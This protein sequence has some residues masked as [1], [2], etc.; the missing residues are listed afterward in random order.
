MACHL[1]VALEYN[2][3]V[4]YNFINEFVKNN[5]EGNKYM[6]IAV[7][8][9]SPRKDK[10]TAGLLKRAA[11]G[12]ESLGIETEL[13]NLY[14]LD[15]KGCVSCFACKLKNG[16]SYGKCA[17]ADGLTPLLMAVQEA[18]GLILGSPIYLKSVTGQMRSF[19]ERLIFPYHTYTEEIKSLFG[20]ELPTAFI[21]TM[22]VTYEQM[23]EI[24]YMQVMKF[25]EE[26]FS[27]IFGSFEALFVNDTYQFDDYS[28][29]VV[30]TF[31]EGKKAR[32][33]EEQFPADCRKAFELGAR[34]ANQ[35]V[36][37]HT[38]EI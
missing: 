26:Y 27:R 11:E 28:K 38:T 18:D 36:K 24:G 25:N 13:V 6:K 4:M 7:V 34:I 37:L 19:M 35:A 21:Y 33:R 12:V 3:I 15:Y 23:N 20:R 16:K 14:D 5:R 30:T 17:Y 29:Y 9:G 10:N 32:V 2:D 22:N 31:D 8:N 1:H